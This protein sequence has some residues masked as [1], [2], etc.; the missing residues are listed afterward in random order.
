M[1]TL[2]K[3]SA[4]T[5]L[6]GL[7]DLDTSFVRDLE[8]MYVPWSGD[9]VP[10]PEIVVLNEPLAR[11]LGLDPERLRS[12]DGAALLAGSAP[13]A[14]T[15]T[16]AMAYSGHQ[17]GNF[18]PLLGDGRALLLGEL[19][20]PDG[21]RRDL[22][23]KGSG[24]TPFAR[25]GDGKAVLGPMLRE[26]LVSEAMHA[27][28]IP[29]TRSLAVTSTGQSVQRE[30]PE[31]GAVLARIASSHLR[32]GS[33][34][35]AVRRGPLVVDLTHYAIARHH[36][37]LLEIDDVPDRVVAFFERVL[38]A[39]ASLIAQYMGVGFIHG[40]LNTDNTTIS[41][42]SIDYGPC[43]FLDAHDPT[44]VFS[45]ID[46]IGR[47]A[48]GNQPAVIG[49][50]LARLAEALIPLVGARDDGEVDADAAIARLTDSLSTYAARYEHHQ[51][52]VT[53]RK[54]GLRGAGDPSPLDD[55]ESSLLTDLETVMREQ[56]VDH[57]GFFRALSVDLWA[58]ASGHEPTETAA[59]APNP[60]TREWLERWFA[61]L[62]DRA[63][64]ATADGMDAVNPVVVPRN[65]LV[66]EALRAGEA[67]DMGPFHALF[68]AVTHPFD[69]PSDPRFAL[70]APDGF[71]DGFRTFCGT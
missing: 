57:T 33:F 27:L 47:Y 17:F 41:G 45:S 9:V 65:H 69:A 55:D 1:A 15:T 19:V 21:T 5:A 37:D 36:P 7:V 30:Q 52:A 53:A 50:N 42:E 2:V 63:T 34:E 23:L 44:T 48:F 29:T 3:V 35:F 60:G 71:S 58:H 25:G 24:R 13:P 16:V 62:G 8:G 4:P 51:A 31:P 22:H 11:E 28:G 20:A 46:T 61:V 56:R 38:D 32:V 59:L 26:Y 70:P 43:A 39:Q 64:T 67:G 18:S 54:I 66:D 6:R 12:A 49:W 40:V 10:D 14:D 68:A